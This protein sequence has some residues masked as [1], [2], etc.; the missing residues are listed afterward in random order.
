MNDGSVE[1]LLGDALRI[2]VEQRVSAYLGRTWRQ[3]KV[4]DKAD[5][6]SHPAAILSDET[7]SVFVKMG[8]G[9]LA[10]DQ[11]EQER[12]GL[13]LLTERSGVLTPT[14]IDNIQVGSEVLMI[15]KAVQVVERQ[16]LHWRQMGQALARIHSVK[17]DR[18][19]LETHCYWGDLFQDNSPLAD[20]PEFFWQRRV[21]PRLKAAVDSG[22][23]PLDL[24]P[25][26]DK[27]GVRF[28]QLCGP[29][30]EPSLLHGDAHQNNIL[31]C[32]QGPVM[33]DPS[34]YYGH[35][36]IDLSYVDFFAPVPDELF[37]GYREMASLDAG[38]IQRRD[39]W[40]IPVWLAMVQVCSSPYLDDLTA[41]LS[42]Y[43]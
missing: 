26:L 2:P 34:V 8:E 9:R 14:V 24:V 22:H 6:A 40:R 33:I 42:R 4:Q 27:L 23:L 38:F 30:V 29:R 19:G 18:Y 37:E 10:V 15:M 20:W 41:T 7:F 13:K 36:E 21:A 31:S 39:L 5:S 25:Q 3:E 43:V 35:P 16:R 12:L 32:T 1:R 28:P 17:W 11:F